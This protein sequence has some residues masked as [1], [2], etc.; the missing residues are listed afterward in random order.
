MFYPYT[1]SIIT[2]KSATQP[3]GDYCI[4]DEDFDLDLNTV[5]VGAVDANKNLTQRT[6]R[7]KPAEV[8]VQTIRGLQSQLD[9]TNAA[10]LT[11]MG[12]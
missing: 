8:L 5:I 7:A 10:I 4:S 6:V 11:I 12:V 1:D 3:A 2:G 9:A